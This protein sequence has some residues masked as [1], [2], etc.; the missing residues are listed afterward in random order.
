M[1]FMTTY[2]NIVFKESKPVRNTSLKY[3]IYTEVVVFVS[4]Y[5]DSALGVY[6]AADEQK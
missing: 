1:I 4:L 6:Q 3:H 2:S 5:I